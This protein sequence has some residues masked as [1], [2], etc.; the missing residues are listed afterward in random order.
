M[1]KNT[2]FTT[3]ELIHYTRHHPPIDRSLLLQRYV[4]SKF[5]KELTQIKAPPALVI[6]LGKVVE[7]LIFKLAEERKLPNHTYLTGFPHPSGAN[8]HRVKQFQQQKQQLR[9]KVKV[10]GDGRE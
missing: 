7:Q 3:A 5:P 6:P 2:P 8:V 4:C 1:T 10:W 9:E